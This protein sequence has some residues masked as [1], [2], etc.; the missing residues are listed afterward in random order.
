MKLYDWDIWHTYATYFT[1]S[2]PDLDKAAQRLVRY[3]VAE[4]AVLRDGRF[5][6]WSDNRLQSGTSA[7][8]LHPSRRTATTT[9]T[10]GY[11]PGFAGEA[12]QQALVFRFAEKRLLGEAGQLPPPYVR[13]YV[14]EC[15]LRSES[16]LFIVYPIVTL[17]ETGVVLVEM[18]LFAPDETIEHPTFITRY[19]NLFE[20][21]F[22]EIWTSPGIVE[23]TGRTH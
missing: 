7:V 10:S 21:A 3:S 11:P 13:A 18:R 17:Y 2:I 22:Y 6:W 16:E 20:S 8:L 12:L 23:L 9:V 5:Y 15:R 4:C 19:V 14:G 1:K